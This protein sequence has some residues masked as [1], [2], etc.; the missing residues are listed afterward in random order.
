M[1]I[2]IANKIA[3][4]RNGLCLS[5]KYVNNNT[6][7]KWSCK[8]GHK[9]N[10]TLKH[11]KNDKSWCP[12]CHFNNLKLSIKIA[13]NIAKK[14]NGK[15][16]SEKYISCDKKLVWKCKNN[17]LWKA[18][19]SSIKNNKTWCPECISVKKL[20]L[21]TARNVAK[22][23]YGKCLSKK[24]INN[25][26]HLL[27]KCENGHKWYASLDKVKNFSRWCPHCNMSEAQK[28]LQRILENL[29]DKKSKSNFKGFDWLKSTI[30]NKRLEIDIWFPDIKLAVEY[31][32]EQH[33]SPIFGKA[34]FNKTKKLDKMKDVIIKKH[35][36][37]IKYFIRFSCKE[38]LNKKN[39]Y[40]KI[41]GICR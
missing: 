4:K 28:K 31:D 36:E 26:F 5:K 40:K 21:K 25:R 24:Y 1:S 17:H 23:H 39:V 22:K 38:N 37:D 16:L 19:L 12:R 11:I 18:S 2:D 8:Y 35:P 14:R 13:Y 9:W 34:I 29:F 10:A 3:K 20:D 33:F 27:W 32:G 30:S 6:N 41:K 7:L 15:C